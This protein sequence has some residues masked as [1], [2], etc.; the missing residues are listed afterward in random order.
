MTGPYVVYRMINDVMVNN[1]PV[2]NALCYHNTGSILDQCCS[3]AGTA[4]QSLTF[5]H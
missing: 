1:E 3:N 5:L 2:N 4:S